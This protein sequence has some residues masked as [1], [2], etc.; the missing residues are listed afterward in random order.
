MMQRVTGEALDRLLDLLAPVG[1]RL[2]VLASYVP[3]E[4]AGPS[5]G[6]GPA[7]DPDAALHAQGRALRLRHSTLAA[8]ALAARA[9]AAGFHHIRVD[10]ALT[11]GSETVRVAVAPGAQPT[12]DGPDEVAVD[13]SVP[14]EVSPPP[15]PSRPASPPT[16]HG[17]S[18]PRR[19]RTG[20]P[21]SPSR[22]WRSRPIPTSP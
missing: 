5:P 7:P 1:G 11:G 9:F 21:P 15:S 18:W 20:S 14:L 4:T 2:T 19:A 13:E 12:V 6:P 8:P 3:Q 16:A 17:S 22:R 10:P